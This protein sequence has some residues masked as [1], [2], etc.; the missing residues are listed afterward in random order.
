[1]DEEFS[2][3]EPDVVVR[4]MVTTPLPGEAG[5]IDQPNLSGS[6]QPLPGTLFGGTPRVASGVTRGDKHKEETRVRLV[7]V[8]DPKEVCGGIIGVGDNKKF[9]A[10]HPSQCEHPLTHSKRKFDLEPN[11]LY[12][13]SSKKGGMHATLLPKLDERCIPSDKALVDLLD[14]ERPI[15]MWHVYFDGC[16]TVEDATG[17]NELDAPSDLSWEVLARPS[18]EDLERAND[19]KTPRKVRVMPGFSDPV[20]FYKMEYLGHIDP[21]DL[22]GLLPIS[23]A[24]TPSQKAVRQMFEGW[25][26]IKENFEVIW[27][28][29][30]TEGD[31]SQ[32]GIASV[33]AQLQEAIDYLNDIGAK[34]RLLSAKIGRNPRA[35]TE[36]DTTLWEAFSEL[37]VELKSIKLTVGNA[38]GVEKETVA[39]L[40]KHDSVIDRLDTNMNKLYNHYKGHLVTNNERMVGVEKGVSTLS[41]APRAQAQDG[42]FDFGSNLASS[43]TNVEKELQS[44]RNE[45][46]N[47]KRVQASSAQDIPSERATDNLFPSS[48]QEEILARLKAV[49]TRGTTGLTVN[50][51]G[52]KFTSEADLI[53]YIREHDI[54]TCAMYWDL[55]SMMVCMGSEGVTGKER[56]DKI[57]SAEKGHTGSALEGDLVA[58]MSHKRPLCLYGSG[59]K[60][61]PLDVG[62]AKC[63]TYEHW[64]GG[65]EK[66]S[67][68]QELS[69]QVAVYTDGIMG[70]IGE[71]STP[72]HHLAQV[73]LNQVGSQWNSIVG[74]ID[75]FYLELVAKAKFNPDKAWKLV[76]RCVASIFEATQPFRAKVI[77]LENST[78]IDQ[79]AAFMWAIF[80]THRVIK[81]FVDVQF[82]SH[83]AIVKEISLFMVT[84]R[85]DPKEIQELGVKCK[86]AEGDAAKA[87]ADLKKLSESH[88][89][90]KRKHESLMADFK[91]VKAKVK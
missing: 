5:P 12:I 85:V 69:D 62:F 4:S 29:L 35:V 39:K 83:P 7:H 90:L 46:S 26:V 71:P 1:M 14:D 70:Q 30:T 10:A 45:I 13:M 11:T 58:S 15:A 28:K 59:E 31:Q 82:K 48:G 44:L 63:T 76:A 89:E 2:F 57:Y 55:F 91:L 86:K 27:A 50:L 8:S 20:D 64:I 52:T 56:S 23:G 54:S 40:E 80:Q 78:K 22:R 87:V 77:L 73:L 61:A 9:C 51:G 32:A 88:N 47:I 37:A 79:K 19:F 21:L 53:V 25:D 43:S 67:Y 38:D 34:A 60:L 16:N 68:R 6:L 18:L 36:G 75:R 17:Q 49:E 66:F 65:G 3:E 42:D 81:S 24:P 74:F 84:E 33:K 41:N 72:A